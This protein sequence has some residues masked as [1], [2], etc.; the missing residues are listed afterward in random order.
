MPCDSKAA[1]KKPYS[2]PSSAV[3]DAESAKAKLTT[4]GDPKDANLQEML[5]LSERQIDRQKTKS[6]SWFRPS[7]GPKGRMG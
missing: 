6:H 4:M 5:S 1:K 2:R 3:L 7:D